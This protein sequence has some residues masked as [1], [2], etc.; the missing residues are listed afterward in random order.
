MKTRKVKGLLW[1]LICSGFLL[2]PIHDDSS[3]APAAPIPSSVLFENA[4]IIDGKGGYLERGF[5]LVEGASIVQI[6]DSPPDQ[7]PPN[8]LRI[9]LTGKT[10]M[11]ALIDAHA[12]VGYEGHTGWGAEYYSREN[13]IDHLQR[14]AYYGFSAIFSAGSDAHEIALA[15]EQEQQR[16][17]L[18]GTR[19]LFAAGMAPPAAGPNELF[20]SHT[21]SIE[22]TTE[23]TILTAVESSTQAR[24]AVQ[25]IASKGIRFIKLWVDD[26]GGTQEKLTPELYSAVLD[27]S[28]L[29]GLTVF[30][31]QQSANDML[32]LSQQGIDG[33]LHGRIG[34]SLNSEIARKVKSNDAFVIPNLGLAELR[35]ETIGRDGFLA[36][37]VPPTTAARLSVIAGNRE[38]AP[39]LNEAREIELR[40]GLSRLME[41]GVDIVLG[42][43]SGALPDHFFGYS[44]HREL[45]IFVRLGMSPMEA[46][47]AASS[48]PARHLNLNNLGVL[49]AGY[50]ADFLILNENP[51]EDIRNT[52]AIENVYLQGRRIDRGKILENLA[53]R[54]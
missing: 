4:H 54:Y 14:Y 37:T 53:L 26:R 11:P 46:I 41:E 9:N 17:E 28:R 39:T 20:L 50:S 23:M 10:L 29:Q 35:R 12:H 51:L 36:I 2:A 16:G 31:H 7:L 33:F 38:L 30:V 43:D 48:T 27:E 34:A 52:R 42:T 8:T 32:Q 22:E 15:L 40:D 5:L 45:E 6:S 49:D 24:L 44:G 1:V 25:Q 21:I 47:I 3:A 19:F 13:I 18:P